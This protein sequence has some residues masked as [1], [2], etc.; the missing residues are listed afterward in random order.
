MFIV[1]HTKLQKNAPTTISVVVQFYILCKYWFKYIITF[2]VLNNTVSGYAFYISFMSK[3]PPFKRSS[4]TFVRG[5][6]SQSVPELFFLLKSRHGRSTWALCPL[7]A[8]QR[9][10]HRPL[11]CFPLASVLP[12]SLPVAI[13]ACHV[14]AG[15]CCSALSFNKSS[16]VLEGRWRVQTT[17][18]TGTLHQR[19]IWLSQAH[20][21]TALWHGAEAKCHGSDG[22]GRPRFEERKVIHLHA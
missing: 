18:N 15:S 10:S 16:Y 11:V 6:Q 21:Q 20:W 22:E 1:L 2:F 7:Q 17:I 8:G 14:S 12:A 13:V 9:S 3:I 5:R 19:V 4:H